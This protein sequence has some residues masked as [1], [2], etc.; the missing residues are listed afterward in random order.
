MRISDWSPDVCAADLAGAVEYRAEE[1]QRRPRRHLGGDRRDSEGIDRIVA[2]TSRPEPRRAIVGG[3]RF[4]GPDHVQ[5]IF[6]AGFVA[7]PR[8][9][10]RSVGQACVST[11]RTRW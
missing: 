5:L 9:E 2:V 4:D 10:E 3:E 6:H 8:S 1:E 11:C 7:A